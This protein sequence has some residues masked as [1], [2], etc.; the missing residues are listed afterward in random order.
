[1]LNGL[2]DTDIADYQPYWA[3]RAHLLA[4]AGRAP[5]ARVAYDRAIHL[6][7]D[8]AERSFLLAQAATLS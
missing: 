2:H 6:S 5:E 3:V 7:D 4:H 8:S 1:V